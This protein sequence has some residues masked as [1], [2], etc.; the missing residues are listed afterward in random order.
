MIF[1]KWN[2][3]QKVGYVIKCSADQ[4][5]YRILTEPMPIFDQP[6]LEL[7]QELPNDLYDFSEDQ[8]RS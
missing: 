3:V 8:C 4:D 7:Y 5:S 2:H 6:F 1:F